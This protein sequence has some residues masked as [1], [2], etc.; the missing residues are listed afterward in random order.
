MLILAFPLLYV[1][2]T[3]LLDSCGAKQLMTVGPIQQDVMSAEVGCRFR[4]GA[5]GR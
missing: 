3:R 4:I 2:P 5:G 1:D